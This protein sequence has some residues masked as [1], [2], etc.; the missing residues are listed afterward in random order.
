MYLKM[1]IN[2][3]HV[4][5]DEE[6]EN[7]KI[8]SVIAPIVFTL[9]KRMSEL[10]IFNTVGYH[11]NLLSSQSQ[12]T[13]CNFRGSWRAGCRC[14][15]CLVIIASCS[16]LEDT[17]VVSMVGPH[18][19]NEG[20]IVQCGVITRLATIPI[21]LIIVRPAA[22]RIEGNIVL[23]SS[24]V[25]FSRPCCSVASGDGNSVAWTRHRYV[26]DTEIGF[27]KP[28]HSLFGH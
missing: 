6:N 3:V 7:D 18:H 8:M 28:L 9:P 2:N 22:V 11:C 19:R 5:E 27:S 25:R 23:A 20:V 24:S 15:R 21:P 13:A 14:T 17:E 10:I 12:T 26:V 1:T 16:E 4:F